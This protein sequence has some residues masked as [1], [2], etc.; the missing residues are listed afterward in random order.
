MSRIP[1]TPGFIN[2]TIIVV[3]KLFKVNCLDCN[4]EVVSFSGVVKRCEKCSKA[5]A[6]VRAKKASAKARAKR[7]LDKLKGTQPK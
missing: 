2:R 6:K 4:V 7:K 5:I 1:Y 3:D